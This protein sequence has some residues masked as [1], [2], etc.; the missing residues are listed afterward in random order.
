MRNNK[1]MINLY[2]ILTC[3]RIEIDNMKDGQYKCRSVNGESILEYYLSL[4][5]NKKKPFC[6]YYLID[7]CNLSVPLLDEV[8]SNMSFARKDH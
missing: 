5:G 3:T 6:D 7:S 2:E 8:E 1:K 4:H